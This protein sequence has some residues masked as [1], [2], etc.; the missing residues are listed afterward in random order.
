MCLCIRVG[1]R[2]VTLPSTYVHPIKYTKCKT[3]HFT[4]KCSKPT[5]LYTCT[6]LAATHTDS[7]ANSTVVSTA[8]RGVQISFILFVKQ[9]NFIFRNKNSLF[10]CAPSRPVNKEPNLHLHILALGIHFTNAVD[11]AII[12]WRYGNMLGFWN[13][14]QFTQP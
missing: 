13:L 8:V 5:G 1:V 12:G 2:S 9:K 3:T 7:I 14:H 6:T 10:N 11:S 4:P